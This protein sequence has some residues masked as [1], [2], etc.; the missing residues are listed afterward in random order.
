MQ[1]IFIR[2]K[3]SYSEHY[4]FQRKQFRPLHLVSEFWRLKKLVDDGKVVGVGRDL[5]YVRAEN[6]PCGS[7][8]HLG[9]IVQS[10]RFSCL[11]S[12]LTINIISY[13]FILDNP[14]C[15]S[16]SCVAFSDRNRI[17]GVAAK[18]QMVTNIDNT[19]HGFKRLLGRSYNDPAVQ[20]ELRDLPYKVVK[21]NN[22]SIG[23]KV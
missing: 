7:S 16:R 18:N 12:D 2:V 8:G 20:Q 15:W 9:L 11:W 17:L 10:F 19:I 1:I 23:I 22:S 14:R 13:T 6:E 21:Q 4:Y 3:A 5:N